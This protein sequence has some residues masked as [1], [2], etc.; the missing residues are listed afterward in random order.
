[1]DGHGCISTPNALA[2]DSHL[3]PVGRYDTTLGTSTDFSLLNGGIPWNFGSAGTD[4]F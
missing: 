2:T 4:A 3:L 1:M